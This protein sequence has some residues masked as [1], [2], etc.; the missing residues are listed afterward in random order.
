MKN[1]RLM[2]SVKNYCVRNLGLDFCSETNL[3]YMFWDQPHDFNTL[4]KS[5]VKAKNELIQNQVNKEKEHTIN[6]ETV[7]N[8]AKIFVMNLKPKLE[9]SEQQESGKNLEKVAKKELIKK[10]INEFVHNFSF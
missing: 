5:I 10:I 9:Y 3:K 2:N 4:Y 8:Q 1:F 6:K 7:G